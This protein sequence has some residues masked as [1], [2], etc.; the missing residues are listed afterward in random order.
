M[1]PDGLLFFSTSAKSLLLTPASTIWMQCLSD[2][3]VIITLLY[4]IT[5][6]T[7]WEIYKKYYSEN[8]SIRPRH[9]WEDNIKTLLVDM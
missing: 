4:I 9:R 3:T 2:E 6:R 5:P 8:F 7:K 1:S